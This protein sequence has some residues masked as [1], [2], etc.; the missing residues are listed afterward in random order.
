LAVALVLLLALLPASCSFFLQNNLGERR[1]TLTSPRSRTYMVLSEPPPKTTQTAGEAGY[2]KNKRKQQIID[3]STWS[4]QKTNRVKQRYKRKRI[5]ETEKEL[6]SL[7]QTRQAEYDRMVENSR[8]KPSLWSFESLF[9]EPVV[10]VESVNRDLYEVKERDSKTTAEQSGL[11]ILSL[12]T[13]T[14]SSLTAS[15]T[16]PREVAK[17]KSFLYSGASMMRPWREPRSAYL[18]SLENTPSTNGA[19]E[20]TMNRK[21]DS[22]HL[23]PTVPVNLVSLSE[24]T[25]TDNNIIN[26]SNNVLLVESPSGNISVSPTGN[27]TF[28]KIDRD[29]TR[30]VEDRVFGYRRT[31][32]G[33]FEYDTSLM[34]DG[35]VKF[36]DG[37]RL[38]NPLKIN[39][40]RLNYFARKE[41]QHGRVEEAQELYE[42]AVRIDRRDGRAYLGL[43]RCAQR[44]RDFKLA[45]DYLEAGIANSVGSVDEVTGEDDRGA[46]PYL[47][48]ALGCLEEKMGRLA[49]AEALYISAVRS[50]P[51]HAAAWVSLAQ[52]RT[53][54]LGQTANAGRFCYEAAER[55]LKKAGKPKSAYVYTAWAS[56]EYKKA[57]DTRRARELFKQAI[58]VDPKCSAAWLQLGVLEADQENWKDA[59]QCFETVLKFDQRNSRALQAYAIMESQRPDGSSRKA[60]DLF[61][62]ALRTNPRDAGVL[63]AY[64]LFVAKLGDI[65]AARQ[66]LRAGTEVDKRHAP[67]WQA[68]G[69]L[70]T[71][72][73]TSEDARKVFQQGIW[74]CATLSGNQSGGYRCAR[75]WQ[76]WGVL[77]AREKDY[78]AARRCFSRAL[79]ADSRN[80][81][82]ITAW[83]LM[84]E[85]LG[86]PRDARLIFEQA[87][88]RFAAGSEDKVSIWRSYELMEQRLG[89]PTG[90]QQVYLRCM[91]EAITS[92]DGLE[93]SQSSPI[94]LLKSSQEEKKTQKQSRTKEVEVIRWDGGGGEVWLNDR[95][96]ESKVPF[97]MKN[98][99][100]KQ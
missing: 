90:A 64:A 27:V 34:G 78:A 76:A 35:A 62:R 66:L 8:G 81:A 85:Q 61:E 47:T 48:Q 95:A 82:S 75:L 23:L 68:W 74:S 41:L 32:K 84:E 39:A 26:N 5:P 29:L 37:V 89:N 69:V 40:D 91:R 1:R 50:R 83:A 18:S 46:N 94:G 19:M 28:P 100:K 67:V 24:N 53:R 30:M 80:V 79:D 44:R 77:E 97:S 13:P 17:M 20:A 65:K 57:G 33:M 9:P 6:Q 38:G 2:S 88:P 4:R 43:C 52:L 3:A 45:R 15:S 87:L 99:R 49:Q 72:H 71:T 11:P 98:R 56:M 14:P 55:E 51:S 59:Q 16:S 86:N 21:T 10:D 70:E 73:G 93:S 92:N 63:Q 7:A 12:I 42:C 54:K 25:I 22:A 58:K 31:P 60:I 96:I 36:R